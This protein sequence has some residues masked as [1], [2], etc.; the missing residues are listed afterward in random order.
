MYILSAYLLI[1]H[2]VRS[3]LL[4]IYYPQM[5]SLYITSAVSFFVHIIR[6]FLL[7]SYHPLFPIIL[8]MIYTKKDYRKERMI[9]TKKERADDMYKEG[10][11]GCYI[12]RRDLRIIY[13]KKE[14][15]DN[16][17][18]NIQMIYTMMIYTKTKLWMIYSLLILV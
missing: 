7:C 16:I 15:A 18:I 11:C 4:C 2:I 5:P 17:I 8:R 12:Q 10:N 6:T 13:T 14:T 9:W 3:F 1:I